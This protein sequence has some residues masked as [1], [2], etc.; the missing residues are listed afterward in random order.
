MSINT[1][2]TLY[3]YSIPPNPVCNLCYAPNETPE[4][5]FICFSGIMPGALWA[6]PDPEPPNDSY[7]VAIV[8]P[9][10]WQSIHAPF[11]FA[12]SLLFGLT[13]V[14]ATIAGPLSVFSGLSIA[15][16]VNWFPNQIAV[17]AGNHYYGGYALIAH[18]MPSQQI[19]IQ[20]IM[21]LFNILAEDETY[22]RP[23]PKS[24]DEGV[25]RFSRRE[26]ATNILI[27][28]DHS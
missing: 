25:H 20:E 6:P 19:S 22:A 15:G 28:V 26:G 10:H 18:M 27:K 16:C 2:P 12:Y 11:T 4:L 13:I 8:A 23:F 9:C 24:G 5:L 3:D 21:S 7:S 14:S 1:D 17:P